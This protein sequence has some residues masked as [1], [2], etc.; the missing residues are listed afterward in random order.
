[1]PDNFC[2]APFIHLNNTPRGKINPCCVW[3]GPAVG[4]MERGILNAWQN[5][6]NLPN[7]IKQKL[8][9]SSSNMPTEVINFMH[10][11][12]TGDFTFCDKV[13]KQEKIHKQATR[14][15]LNYEK[16]FPEWWE[17]LN[18]NSTMR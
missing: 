6:R 7:N 17:I 13:K 10:Q 1:M 15:T 12:P 16:L 18:E 8:L 14:K 3:D 11:K 2:I 4:N 9:L 5:I